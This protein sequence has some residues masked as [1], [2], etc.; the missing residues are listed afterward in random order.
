[1]SVTEYASD[2][3]QGVKSLNQEYALTQR[4]LGVLKVLGDAGEAV[5]GAAG[6]VTPEPATTIGG[7][8]LFVHGLDVASSGLNEIWTGKPAETLTDQAVTEGAKLQGA[9]NTTAHQLGDSV[10]MSLS[11]GSCGV[12]IYKTLTRPVTAQLGC[13]TLKS[14]VDPEVMDDLARSEVSTS[15]RTAMGV[16]EEAA[17]SGRIEAQELEKADG[18]SDVGATMRGGTVG[19]NKI[20]TIGSLAENIHPGIK[21]NIL[22]DVDSDQFNK[23]FNKANQTQVDTF[24]SDFKAANNVGPEKNVAI[25]Q[26]DFGDET[27]TFAIQNGKKNLLPI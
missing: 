2:T 25:F 26:L 17:S 27:L 7:G 15:P 4:G 14:K 10:D 19:L 22:G 6:I 18:V 23:V 8:I 21:R 3:W 11:L 12:G 13:M 9:D 5:V 20:R 16:T 1:V 24:I